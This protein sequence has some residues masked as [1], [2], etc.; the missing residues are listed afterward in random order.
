[1]SGRV[2]VDV[3]VIM[4][5]LPESP[6]EFALDGSSL[7]LRAYLPGNR[8][9]ELPC[10]VGRFGAQLWIRERM[11]IVAVLSENAVRVQFPSD[12]STRI[13]Y[14]DE[15][16]KAYCVGD[17]LETPRIE[18]ASHER[19]FVREVGA[20]RLGAMKEETAARTGVEAV[21]TCAGRVSAKKTHLRGFQLRYDADN[22]FGSFV[23]AKDRVAWL[24]GFERTFAD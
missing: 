23:G 10:P 24:I 8:M 14:L 4:A 2:H 9:V 18:W 12:D 17:E 15:S 20:I 7:A 1:M 11:K 16:D 6:T 13:I 3:L 22:T 19:L 21:E 5:A